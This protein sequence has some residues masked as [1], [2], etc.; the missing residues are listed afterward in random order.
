MHVGNVLTVMMGGCCNARHALSL[1]I[2]AMH[3]IALR[4]DH[5]SVLNSILTFFL[6]KWNGLFFQKSSLH[7]SGLCI[8][9]GHGGAKCISPTPGP[10]TFTVVDVSG[11][12]KVAIDFC[13]CH[14]NGI[15]PHHI[16][17][18]RAGWLP[19]TFIHPQTAFTFHCLDFYHELMHM[20]FA[21]LYSTSLI[22]WNLIKH[23]FVYFD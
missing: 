9:L 12:H 3:C 13:N 19:A 8:Q 17:L 14:T 18:L 22:V 11:I 6:K 5:S 7:N 1:C 15:I 20:T 2:V 21:N 4:Y 23:R 10:I 16:Q